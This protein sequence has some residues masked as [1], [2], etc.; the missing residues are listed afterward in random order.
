MPGGE[1]GF[2]LIEL[3]TALMLSVVVGLA[4]YYMYSASIATYT[5]AEKELQFL[6]G[7]RTSTDFM[8]REV[9]SMCWKAGYLPVTGGTTFKPVNDGMLAVHFYHHCA[10]FYTS[11]D[12]I[13]IDWVAY[14]FNPPEPKVS[15]EDGVDNDNDDPESVL[16][17]G[18]PRQGLYL[19]VDDKGSMM[20]QRRLDEDLLYEDYSAPYADLIPNFTSQGIDTGST[21]TDATDLG[22]ILAEG[23][24]EIAFWYV[25][26]KPGDETLYYSPEWPAEVND[27]GDGDA[28]DDTGFTW[29]GRG[30]SYLTVPLGIQI[31]FHY[32]LD[33]VDRVLSKLMLIYSS[34]WHELSTLAAGAAGGGGG[35]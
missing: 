5:T 11:L 6:A 24:T 17:P 23:F 15:W 30:L 8:E 26:S 2:T 32:E 25:Y 27:T 19:L 12:G 33:G 7:F 13:H 14:Y 35:G 34:K 9:N 21:R 29:G 16:P 22:D 20:R 4:V 3:M 28:S 31:D 1:G 18:D 10:A